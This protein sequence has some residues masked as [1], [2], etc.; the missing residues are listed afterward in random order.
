VGALTFMDQ[1]VGRFSAGGRGRRGL[2]RPGTAAG[3]GRQA[4]RPP[5]APSSTGEE[6]GGAAA[7]HGGSAGL[8]PHARANQAAPLGPRLAVVLT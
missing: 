4:G 6:A 1:L 5:S 8:D 3:A 7:E 2:G